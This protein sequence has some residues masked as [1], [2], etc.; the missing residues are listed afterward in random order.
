MYKNKIYRLEKSYIVDKKTK[1]LPLN[2]FYDKYVDITYTLNACRKC[3]IYNTNWACPEFN[4][5]IMDV[6]NEYNNI[7]LTLIK[8]RYD[9]EIKNKVFTSDEIDTLLHVSLFKEKNNQIRLYHKLEKELDAFYLSTGYCSICKKCSRLDGN[10]CRYPSNKRYSMEALGT[11]VVKCVKVEFDEE[12]EWIDY[13]KGLIPSNL[14][15]L[16]GLLY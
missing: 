10:P 11:L 2:V 16:M 3:R 13:D 15:L 12:I 5:D 7:E 14:M 1:T 6:W 4:E 8:L 9:D